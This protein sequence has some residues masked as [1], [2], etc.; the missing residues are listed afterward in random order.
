MWYICWPLSAQHITWLSLMPRREHITAKTWHKNKSTNT[1]HTEQHSI[2]QSGIKIFEN[3]KHTRGK[4]SIMALCCFNRSHICIS[5]R[6]N[7]TTMCIF[8]FLYH[9]CVWWAHSS[10]LEPWHCESTGQ[11]QVQCMSPFIPLSPRSFSLWTFDSW[12]QILSVR[13]GQL[14]NMDLVI[15][16]HSTNTHNTHNAH[17]SAILIYLP[18]L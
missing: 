8:L 18:P 12:Y 16:W 3:Y 10:W 1:R 11:W 9:C 13:P 4:K 17:F 7:T 14:P 2:L 5:N 6:V 15:R